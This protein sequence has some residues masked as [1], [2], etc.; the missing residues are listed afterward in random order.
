MYIIGL[1]GP[2]RAGKSTTAQVLQRALANHGIDSTIIPMAKPL[3]T[4]ATELGWDGQKDKKGRRLL[5]LL[6]TQVCRECISQDYWTKKFLELAH[7]SGTPVVICDDIRFDDEAEICD[8]VIRVTGR[9]PLSWRLTEYKCLRWLR[10]FLCHASERGVTRCDYTINN[11]GD[12][13][14]LAN[15]VYN[16]LEELPCVS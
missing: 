4:I 9:D 11:D 3:K 8:K 13:F 7:K 14:M 1:S 6:G 12:L 5:Q 15:N 2:M 10:R 16:A